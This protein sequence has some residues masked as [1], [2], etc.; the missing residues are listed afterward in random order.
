MLDMGQA[1]HVCTVAAIAHWV[2]IFIVICG[3][4]KTP[5]KADLAIIRWGYVPIMVV[6]ATVG[7]LIW[8]PLGRW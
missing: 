4:P 1:L 5:T 7:P 2:T 8:A 3:R 6:I